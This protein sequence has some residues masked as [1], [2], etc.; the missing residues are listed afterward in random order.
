MISLA[1][2]FAFDD[3]V[4][5]EPFLENMYELNIAAMGGDQIQLSVIERPLREDPVLTF[6]QKY[7]KRNN[8]NKSSA[9]EGMASLQRDLDPADVPQ[10]IKEEIRDYATRTYSGLDCQGV[11]R[12][13][14]VVDKN[15]DQIYL[16]EINP[17]PGSFSYYLWESSTPKRTFTE[18]LSDVVEQAIQSKK[19]KRRIKR[20][21]NRQIFKD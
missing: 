11:I 21:L 3:Q 5:V 7:M 1:G 20:Q 8:K 6:E 10:N 13:D 2:A 12:I 14:F 16:N 17:I 15:N 4:L 18:L 9:S 19:A